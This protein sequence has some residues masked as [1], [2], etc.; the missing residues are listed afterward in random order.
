[1]SVSFWLSLRLC[2]HARLAK[3]LRVPCVQSL[4]TAFHNR[5]VLALGMLSI[6]LVLGLYGPARTLIELRR[7]Q[8]ATDVAIFAHQY[9]M[10]LAFALAPG[11]VGCP[12]K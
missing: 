7:K 11:Y 5:A 8:K 2:F 12:P 9:V 3:P 1:M 4:R 10:N 6:G